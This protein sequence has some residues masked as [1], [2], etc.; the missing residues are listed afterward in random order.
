MP[1]NS[2]H[3]QEDL[4]LVALITA[5]NS[6]AEEKFFAKYRLWIEQEVRRRGV[7]AAEVED[8]A[9]NV[10]LSAF[11]QIRRGNFHG[12]SLLKT[13]LDKI[14]QGKV[15]DYWRK[16]SPERR[17]LPARADAQPETASLELV[18]GLPAIKL[19]PELV[20]AV[21]EVLRQMPE[22]L[23]QVL[24][25]NRTGGYTIRDISHSLEMTSGQVAKRL[26][27]AEE[28]F[29]RLLLSDGQ[30]RESGKAET[31]QIRLKSGDGN[32]LLFLRQRLGCGESSGA[33]S[34]LFEVARFAKSRG[35]TWLRTRFGKSRYTLLRSPNSAYQ[36]EWLP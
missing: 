13:W 14:I 12:Q 36:S 3:H 1:D 26:Y 15:N 10:L 6:A 22:D 33:K 18:Q 27:K 23:A 32:Q 34:K 28:L 30:R 17:Q 25:L 35:F 16:L 8:I 9:Q 2:D 4:E 21:R 7:T 24:I 20:I 11:D 29:R 19:D 5:G 31:N